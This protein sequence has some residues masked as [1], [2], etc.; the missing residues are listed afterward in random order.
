VSSWVPDDERFDVDMVAMACSGTLLL[1]NIVLTARHCVT[2]DGLIDG[3]IR[4][5][6]SLRFGIGEFPPP[7]WNLP[8]PCQGEARDPSCA[9][10]VEVA[11]ADKNIDL[12]VVRLNGPLLREVPGA[13]GT[14]DRHPFTPLEIN[15][16][17]NRYLNANVLVSGWGNGSCEGGDGF[18]LRHGMTKITNLSFGV[19]SGDVTYKPLAHLERTAA[20]QMFT[21][22]DSGGPTWG[23]DT[24]P[25]AVIGVHSLAYC[26]TDDDAVGA[27][28]EG[29]DVHL[30]RSGAMSWLRLAVAGLDQSRDYTEPLNSLA[31]LD[32][33]PQAGSTPDY[34]I[35]NGRLRQRANAAA[36][37][38]LIQDEIL[39]RQLGAKYSVKIAS[40]DN[41]GGGIV[42]SYVD[43][44]NYM[45]CQ[46][47]AQE[48]KLSIVVM[49]AGL[50][51]ALSKPW[52]GN[53]AQEVTITADLMPTPGP[54]MTYPLRCEVSG[55]GVATQS[56][57]WS[58]PGLPAGRVGIYNEWLDEASYRDFVVDSL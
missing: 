9:I 6:D 5:A 2:K 48:H 11:A 49:R 33:V 28:A 22:G 29:A 17:A 55:G 58:D 25:P 53:Y 13:P 42:F 7:G 3:K 40:S 21:N 54:S 26:S 47:N 30:T 32:V 51:Q 38:V 57:T 16:N 19:R 27:D 23:L 56:L 46:T 36:S 12:A 43:A 4:R 52:L 8:D 34:A 50:R 1:P 18:T 15:P 41:D 37:M 35:V 14:Y 10:G 39:Q 20:N 45:L 24:M 31:R 44:Q